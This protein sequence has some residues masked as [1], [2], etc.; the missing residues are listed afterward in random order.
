MGYNGSGTFV[1]VTNWQG[2]ASAGIKI[3]ADRHDLQDDEF[4]TGLSQV[5]TK[6]G[7][8][9]P[10]ADIPLNGHKLVSVG[11]P[12]NPQDAAT[13]KY[14]DEIS[15]FTTS[16]SLAGADANGRLRFTSTTGV[17]GLSFVGAD[18][19][20]FAKLADASAT[21][22]TINRM[23]LNDKP[24]GSGTDVIALREDGTI[25]GSN[26]I[27]EKADAE[28]SMKPLSGAGKIV[29]YAA[30]GTVRSVVAIDSGAQADLVITTGGKTVTLTKDGDVKATRRAYAADAYL[31]TNG[32]IGTISGS[33]VWQGWGALDA[34]SA[35][36][37][38][39][40]ARANERGQAWANDR[41]A[42]L[43]YRR[44]SLG[45]A[46]MPGWGTFDLPAGTVC[47][48]ATVDNWEWKSMRY[49]Y[50]QVFDPVRGWVGFSG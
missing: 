12:T 32:N 26:V 3:K 9:Q 19:G 50:L 31:E 17:N 42:N 25:R 11:D 5:I 40:E 37:A 45:A 34:F 15:S 30:D 7:Q 49:M 22:P 35:I 24:D 23:V 29:F 38:R 6:D 20:W 10:T 47:T 1:R 48:G 36:N 8:S 4:A 27:I 43:Q 14:V 13:K 2:D 18:L 21:P 46:G 44:T 28:L 33:S 16:I 41:V 39:I